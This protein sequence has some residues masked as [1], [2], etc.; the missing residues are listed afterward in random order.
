MKTIFTSLLMIV[1][2]SG[3]VHA[4]D[5]H[6]NDLLKSAWNSALS[7]LAGLRIDLDLQKAKG[8]SSAIGEYLEV[9]YLQKFNEILAASQ[10]LLSETQLEA[11]LAKKVSELQSAM[12]TGVRA[13]AHQ[14]ASQAT[15]IKKA[16]G[17]WKAE[18]ELYVSLPF[19]MHFA[20]AT[21]VDQN[22]IAFTGYDYEGRNFQAGRMNILTQKIETQSIGL[23]DR[24]SAFYPISDSKIYID[25]NGQLLDVNPMTSEVQSLVKF[26]DVKSNREHTVLS[27]GTHVFRDDLSWM[28]FDSATKK[29]EPLPESFSYRFG[30]QLIPI[31]DGR[32][33]IVGGIG[34]M[35]EPFTSIEGVDSGA[36]Q[37]FEFAGT[38]S[39]GRDEFTATTLSDGR[40][41]LI[42]GSKRVEIIDPELETVSVL[43]ELPSY[44]KRP[45]VTLLDNDLILVSGGLKKGG[46]LQNSIVLINPH[47]GSVKKIGA[48]KYKRANHA[49]VM[50]SETEFLVL[51]GVGREDDVL[52][53]EKIT[54]KVDE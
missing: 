2:S 7:D 51:G 39:D 44:T 28:G 40:I 15:A 9:R 1:L 46:L 23:P 11:I 41:V 12:N 37:A 48:L 19:K 36:F 47:S 24:I 31:R 18:S 27:D 16:Q 26:D 14:D 13:T 4:S 10:P 30:S 5:H 45:A 53:T 54:L 52:T 49:Q 42:G 29:Y 35:G 43:G 50:L 34:E 17:L 3:P 22:T 33:L 6:C 8:P 25:I 21:N 20:F 38:L 32:F